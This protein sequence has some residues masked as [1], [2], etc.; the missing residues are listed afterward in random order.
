M[1]AR[2]VKSQC[3]PGWLQPRWMIR[4][5]RSGRARA[6]ALFP[7]CRG[8][9][10]SHDNFQFQPTRNNRLPSDNPRRRRR[11]ADLLTSATVRDI[12]EYIDETTR[13]RFSKVHADRACHSRAERKASRGENR[14]LRS[15]SSLSISPSVTRE[16]R[17]E[18]VRA[19][20]RELGSG[21]ATFFLPR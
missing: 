5:S 17:H 18:H 20:S 13:F 11:Y 10:F 4:F 8:N 7:R 14:S 19:A 9:S 21:S 3:G 2:R 12:R 1:S 6:R 16:R 15:P